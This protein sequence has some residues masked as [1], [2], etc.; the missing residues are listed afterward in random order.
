VSAPL[1]GLTAGTTYYYR[2]TATNVDGTAATTAG[3]FTTTAVTVPKFNSMSG[4]GTSATSFGVIGN[5]LSDGGLPITERGVRYRVAGSTGAYTSVTTSGTTGA[6]AVTITGLTSATTYEYYPYAVNG[7]GEGRY[8]TE[9]ATTKRLTALA[10]AP[11]GLT[12]D[13]SGTSAKLSFT[14][15]D[16]GGVAISNYEVS[17]DNGATWQAMNPAATASPLTITGLTPGVTYQ[18]KVRAVTT[19]GSGTASTAV[20]VT[21]PTVLAITSAVSA[22]GTYGT[23]FSYQVAG[24]GAPT[25]FSATGLPTGLSINP[26]NGAITGTPTQTGSFTVDLAIGTSTASAK[27]ALEITI[28]KRALTVTA[29]AKSRGYGQEDPA[30]TATLSG[31][32]GTDTVA[33][34]SGSPKF[35]VA[36]TTSSPPETYA[37]MPAVGSLT[38]TNYSFGT[39]SVGYLTITAQAATVTLGDLAQTYT[40]ATRPVKVTTA[41]AGLSVTLSYAGT[42]ATIYAASATPPTDAGSYAVTATVNDAGYSGT[43]TQ[44]LVVAKASQTITIAPLPTSV[45]LNTLATVAITAS[46]SSGLPVSFGLDTGSAAAVGLSAAVSPPR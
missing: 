8:F 39:F 21:A 18:V 36:A 4:G 44:T 29:E 37:I 3:T 16:N 19:V 26:S 1:T 34:V 31:F 5:V 43:T 27:R 2:L 41:P 23:A 25:T 10:A 46:A 11:T 35:S 33:V 12:A 9:K 40:G 38:A 30:F 7:F 20:A 42:G 6:F 22:S 17:F 32:V 45:A 14:P 13:V 15:G 28:A 24:S